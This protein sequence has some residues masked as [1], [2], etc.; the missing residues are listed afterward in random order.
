MEDMDT[1]WMRRALAQAC[2]AAEAGEV[3]I[4]ALIVREHELVGQAHNQVELL[5]DP[6]AH[7]EMLA[8]TQAA[9]ALGDW[10]L[11]DT[12]LYVTKEP[13]PMCAG[14]IVL[15][16]IPRVVWAVPDPKRGGA[17]SVF[18]ILEHPNLNHRPE[19]RD[20]VLEEECRELLVAFF[21]EKRQAN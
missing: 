6:T 21:R 8:I 1:R 16:R 17:K 5:H 4:G 20:G 14:A 12:T 3:P 11:L 9:N 7:A 19:L 2:R 10:R 18:N 13:C 15:A